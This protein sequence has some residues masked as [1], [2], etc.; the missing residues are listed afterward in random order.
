MLPGQVVSSE[1]HYNPD[2]SDDYEFVEL[3]NLGTNVVDL[4]GARLAGAVD[5]LFPAPALQV[6]DAQVAQLQRS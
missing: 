4:T 6:P 3:W 5:F 1:I 2:G